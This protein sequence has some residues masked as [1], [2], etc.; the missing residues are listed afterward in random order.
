MAMISSFFNSAYGITTNTASFLFSICCTPDDYNIPN[1]ANPFIE[2]KNNGGVKTRLSKLKPK[3]IITEGRALNTIVEDTYLRYDHFYCHQVFNTYFYS[4]EFNCWVIPIPAIEDMYGILKK[5]GGY[6][7]LNNFPTTFAKN[8]KDVIFSLLTKSIR[9]VNRVVERVTNNA[10]FLKTAITNKEIYKVAVDIETTGL[11]YFRDKIVS[12][13]LCWDSKIA[14]FLEWEDTEEFKSLLREFLKDKFSIC[15]NGIFE[16]RFLEFNGVPFTFSWDV[17]YAGH[18]L[19]SAKGNSLKANAFMS[20]FMG[21]YEFELDS[22][23]RKFKIKD[24]SMIPLDVMSKYAG[25]DVIVTLMLE[26]T[27][28]KMMDERL[29]KLFE[30]TY[31]P[32]ANQVAEMELIGMPVDVNEIEACKLEYEK[33]MRELQKI[34]ESDFP[35]INLDSDDQLGDMFKKLGAKNY[36]IN[37]RG[38]YLTGGDRIQQWAAQG[39]KYADVVTEYNTVSK[40]HS[41]YLQEKG[42]K[43]LMRSYYEVDKRCHPS[44]RLT[45]NWVSRLSADWAQTLPIKTNEAFRRAF[46][47]DENHYIAEVDFSG[48]HLRLIAM[49]SKDPV[50]VEMFSSPNKKLRDMHSRTASAV[51]ANCSF[52]EFIDKMK[53]GTV[54]EKKHMKEYRTLAKILNFS[55]VYGVSPFSTKSRTLQAPVDAGGWTIKKVEEFLKENGVTSPS[56]FV[57]DLTNNSNDKLEEE[58][59]KYLACAKLIHLKFFQQYPRLEKW[60]E[61]MHETAKEKGYAETFYGFKI[62]LPEYQHPMHQGRNEVYSNL[63]N[64]AVNGPIIG[65]EAHIMQQAQVEINNYFKQ[66]NFDAKIINQIHDSLIIEFHK[67]LVDVIKEPIHNIFTKERPGYNGVAVDAEGHYGQ[68]WGGSKDH[69][70]NFWFE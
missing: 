29:L 43:C 20:T 48:F 6:V 22:Y 45:S 9:N 47:C 67:D 1:S 34:V 31:I 59:I 16:K 56:S 35:G 25:Y 7:Q 24:Y 13:Q 8:Q 26:S 50:L 36:G 38:H 65:T 28:R 39:V 19:Y 66:N 3:I 44:F 4:P 5:G 11:R 2:C 30:E 41:T 42:E 12:I 21:G 51:F 27:F 69:P 60:I 63:N 70:W 61:E 62:W 57:S 18:Y 15:A 40:T 23:K 64:V 37:A 10:E 54:A 52:E 68:V 33:R 53:N 32:M 58:E 17:N 14:Y 55:L 46:K 49:M